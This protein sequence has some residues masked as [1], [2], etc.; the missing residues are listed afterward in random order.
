MRVALVCG[1][2]SANAILKRDP[3]LYVTP[4]LHTLSSL[5]RCGRRYVLHTSMFR[6]S[7]T[8]RYV[9]RF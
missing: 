9:F 5:A 1:P 4:S 3:R 6:F 2:R 8:R 7:H